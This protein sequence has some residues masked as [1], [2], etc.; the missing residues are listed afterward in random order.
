MEIKFK[1]EDLEE[2]AKTIKNTDS[3]NIDTIITEADSLEN[4]KFW[5][6]IFEKYNFQ[7]IFVKTL[8]NLVKNIHFKILI[9]S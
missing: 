1:K 8:K 7:N 3:P 9:N 6:E 5:L 2:I 4:L